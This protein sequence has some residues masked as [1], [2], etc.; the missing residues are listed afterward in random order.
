M[1]KSRKL[2]TAIVSAG[3]VASSLAVPAQARDWRGSNGHGHNAH[4]PRYVAPHYGRYDRHDRRR[5]R[6]GKK[7][8][9]GIAIGLGALLLGSIIANEAHRNR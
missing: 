6:T 5:D 4:G 2:I 8:A 9:T 7:I 3:L 1:S